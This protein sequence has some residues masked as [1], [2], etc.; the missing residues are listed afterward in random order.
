MFPW[1][2]FWSP[3]LELPLSGDVGQHFDLF[4]SI[5]PGAGIGEIERKAF[6]K[7]SYGRQIGL[8][9]EVLL[10]MHGHAPVTPAKAKKALDELLQVYAGI[11]EVKAESCAEMARAAARLLETLE[12]ADPARYELLMASF[13]AR[14]RAKDVPR[15]P[16]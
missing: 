10:G 14:S 8:I 16:R 2:W 6:D 11:E 4:D 13:A 15:L 1:I 3:K 9:T 12:R 5:R 7:A